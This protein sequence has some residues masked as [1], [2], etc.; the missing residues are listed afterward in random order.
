MKEWRVV[1][2]VASRNFAVQ[3][4]DGRAQ[5]NRAKSAIDKRLVMEWTRRKRSD[6]INSFATAYYR[7]FILS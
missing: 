4:F 2:G 1:V 3:L 7:R 5:S 6:G